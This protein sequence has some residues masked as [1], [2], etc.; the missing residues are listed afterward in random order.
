MTD[1]RSRGLLATPVLQRRNLP[2]APVLDLS[3]LAQFPGLPSIDVFFATSRASQRQSMG[4]NA[5][6]KW[7]FASLTPMQ[8]AWRTNTAVHVPN[9]GHGR[10]STR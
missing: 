10:A 8:N 2:L 9:V 7:G 1:A 3:T 5:A 6:S 4:A